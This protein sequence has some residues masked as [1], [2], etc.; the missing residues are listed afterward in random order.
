LK[1]KLEDFYSKDDS[2][3]KILLNQNK[4][5]YTVRL[6]GTD[7]C[8]DGERLCK[9]KISIKLELKH[10]FYILLILLSFCQQASA[11]LIIADSLQLVKYYNGTLDDQYLV[12]DT[13][14]GKPDWHYVILY[15]PY[16]RYEI[17]NKID[18]L[19]PKMI[20]GT[21]EFDTIMPRHATEAHKLIFE[22]NHVFMAYDSVAV[23]DSVADKSVEVETILKGTWKISNDT[24]YT[25]ITDCIA[26]CKSSWEI[27]TGD[28]LNFVLYKEKMYMCN[29]EYF[30]KRY[31]RKNQQK[32]DEK[33]K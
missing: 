4:G 9:K 6:S 20:V 2:V 8:F 26:G 7:N 19:N 27:H 5:N 12:K 33:I 25:S 32:V 1:N 31:R 17:I 21:W 24:L 22:K 18:K 11:Q 28:W 30:L 15:T 23:W 10:K 3:I 16:H 14:D 13:I 29:E